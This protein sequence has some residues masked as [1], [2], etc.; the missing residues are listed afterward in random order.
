VEGGGLGELWKRGVRDKA[1]RIDFSTECTSSSLDR[2]RAS[3]PR[4]A[5][6]RRRR[7]TSAGGR[8]SRCAW[9]SGAPAAAAASVLLKRV[10][11]FK[12]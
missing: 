8:S 2:G 7:P 9:R 6:R 4:A 5:S 10:D 11:V 3:G 12:V 1:T